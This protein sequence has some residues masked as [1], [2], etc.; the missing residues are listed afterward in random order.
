MEEPQYTKQGM[1]YY[2]PDYDLAVFANINWAR[3]V[4]VFKQGDA[5]DEYWITSLTEE[6]GEIAGPTKKLSR[7]FNAR[8]L[9]KMKSKLTQGEK[10]YEGDD[11]LLE[12]IWENGLREKMGEEAAD[13]VTYLMLLCTKHNIN[14]WEA[15]KKKF[16]LVSKEMN[17]PEYEIK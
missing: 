8:E 17:C 15:I 3:N 6:L 16:N 11:R 10:E 1:T 13:L 5:T 2:K 7:G 9:K 12:V 14:L 4:N